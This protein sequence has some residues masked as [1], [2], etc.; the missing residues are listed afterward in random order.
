MVD[1]SERLS[2]HF[3]LREMVRTSHRTIN[4]TP[5]PDIVE[6]LRELCVNLLEPV[7]EQFGPLW[8]TSGYRCRSLNTTIRGSYTSAHLHGCAADFVSMEGHLTRHIVQWIADSV[9]DFDQVID[10]YSS[11]SNWV[12]LGMAK[13]DRDP[14]GQVL[15][16][17]GGKYYQFEVDDDS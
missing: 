5:T 3:T 6:N 13:P 2:P 1:L 9:L 17:R 16:M 8:V 10:E 4:N 15:T 12:H 14:R 11:T 7:R